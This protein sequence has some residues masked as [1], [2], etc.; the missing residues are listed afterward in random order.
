MVSEPTETIFTSKILA[1]VRHTQNSMPIKANAKF[2]VC[3][4]VLVF[5]VVVLEYTTARRRYLIEATKVGFS[6]LSHNRARK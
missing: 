2:T 6:A 1:I 4:I 3:F 5:Y